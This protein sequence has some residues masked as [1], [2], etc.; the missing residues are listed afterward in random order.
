M[1]SSGRTRLRRKRRGKTVKRPQM[2]RNILVRTVT[3]TY[4]ADR[5]DA[6]R[7]VREERTV[8]KLRL[9]KAD[10]DAFPLDFALA[11][12]RAGGDGLSLPRAEDG[13]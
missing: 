1:H 11:L 7:L 8:E 4:V 5:T 9:L 3:R 2:Y 6:R 12:H 10:Y 13:E